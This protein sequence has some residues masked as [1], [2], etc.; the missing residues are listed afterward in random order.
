MLHIRIKAAV[1]ILF[2]TLSSAKGQIVRIDTVKTPELRV[3]P[4]EF[5]DQRLYRYTIGIKAFSLEEFPKILKQVNSNEL[6]PILINGVFLKL[7][8][9]Q[10]SYRLGANF[11]KKNISF[12]NECEDCEE[13]NGTVKDFSSRIGFEKNFVYGMLQPYLAF[14]L[15]YRRNSFKGDVKNAS[16]VAFSTPYEV[17]TLKNGFLISPNFGLKLNLLNHLTLGIETGIELLNIY[18]KQETV[19]RDISRT[20]TFK[21]ARKWEFLL[22]PISVASIQYNFG[23]DF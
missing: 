2:I 12:K 5:K 7:N 10:I 6:V 22:R 20:R 9:N 17:N 19:S 4:S 1:F 11:Y 16:S 3:K 23:Q 15:G 14:D 13:A 21:D 8:D 18:E